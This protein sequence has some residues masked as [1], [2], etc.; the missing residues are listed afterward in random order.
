MDDDILFTPSGPDTMC[1]RAMVMANLAATIDA[2]VDGDAKN[3]LL[4]AMD[5]VLC[6]MIPMHLVK[7]GNVIHFK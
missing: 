6:T 5:A 7:E 3:L 4:R 1:D 2:T